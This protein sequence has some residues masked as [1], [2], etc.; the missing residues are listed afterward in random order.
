[1][2]HDLIC[3]SL[4]CWTWFIHLLDCS[5]PPWRWYL[6]K[7]TLLLFLSSMRGILIVKYKPGLVWGRALL[8]GLV[9]RWLGIRKIILVVVLPSFL[10]VINSPLSV[11][12]ALGN[13][14]MHA[15]QATQFIDSTI[16]TPITPQTV[17]NVLKEAG[18]QSATKK[19][20]PML[21]G[22]HCQQHLKF[23][24]Y[25][26]TGVWRTGRGCCGLMRQRSIGLGQMGRCMFGRNE[27]S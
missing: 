12:S 16:T 13:L 26:E 8:A 10:L 27:G 22:S 25:H 4:T 24:Q 5:P 7:S 15:V 23:A 11:K 9:R 19:K 1:M 17:R 6:L 2:S 20:V 21:K 18:L 3:I 14:I